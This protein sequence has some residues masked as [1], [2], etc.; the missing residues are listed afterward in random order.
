MRVLEG[1]TCSRDVLGARKGSG[2]SVDKD[3]PGKDPVA[4]TWLGLHRRGLSAA[5]GPFLRVRARFNRHGRFHSAP[6]DLESFR[7]IEHLQ[8]GGARNRC[9][10]VYNG[11][12][13]KGARVRRELRCLAV[14][15]AA[16]AVELLAIA[17]LP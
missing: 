16:A 3:Q 9:R 15:A 10:R 12:S 14:D 1:G 2:T 11:A 4:C 13:P 6:G 8:G 5:G 17:P 7:I